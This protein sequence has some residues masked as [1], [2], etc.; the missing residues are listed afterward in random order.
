[1]GLKNSQL[2]CVRSR[3]RP[4]HQVRVWTDRVVAAAMGSWVFMHVSS[5]LALPGSAQRQARQE[6]A[7]A[8]GLLACPF[9]GM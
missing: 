9:P 6:A 7:E 4:L 3:S 1:M 2:F 5:G 8:L